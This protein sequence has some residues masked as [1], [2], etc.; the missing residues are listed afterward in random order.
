MGA[1]ASRLRKAAKAIKSGFASVV[2]SKLLIFGKEPEQ[3]FDNQI[4]TGK[5]NKKRESVMEIQT[6]SKGTHE[7]ANLS[8]VFERSYTL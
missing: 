3:I 1:Q 8:V 2:K 4:T 5:E 6:G 7:I